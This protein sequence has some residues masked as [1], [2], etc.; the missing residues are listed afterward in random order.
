[1][2]RISVVEKERRKL[3]YDATIF[4]IFVEE[5]WNSLTYERL[6]QE[7]GLSKSTLQGYYPTRVHFGTALEGK[8]FHIVANAVDFSNQK[9]IR[10]SWNKG[11][12]SD[13]L[14]LGANEMMLHCS[15]SLDV[16]RVARTGRNNLVK[17]F[18]ETMS[19]DEAENLANLL[20]GDT[21]NYMLDR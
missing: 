10:D 15:L 1:M 11:L 5:G 19:V 21:V 7:L 17:K 6:S 9:T 8:I 13:K 4:S 3:E 16:N 14:F 18:S 20:L 12:E 2:A